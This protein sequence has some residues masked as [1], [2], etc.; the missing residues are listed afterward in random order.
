MIQISKRFT[1][2][3]YLFFFVCWCVCVG[4]WG[5]RCWGVRVFN[6]VPFL[7]SFQTLKC[8]NLITSIKNKTKQNTTQHNT[9]QHNTTQHNTTQHNTTQQKNKTKQNKTKQKTKRK[10]KKQQQQK[11]NSILS[12]NYSK[13]IENNS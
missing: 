3:A 2:I 1:L 6:P 5:C 4:V 11:K 13:T 8:F 7:D 12:E 10:I 9:T